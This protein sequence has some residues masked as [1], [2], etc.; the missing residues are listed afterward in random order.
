MKSIS[1]WFFLAL[2]AISCTPEKKEVAY[3]PI[4]YKLY[5]GDNEAGYF[6]SWRSAEGAYQYEMEYND[7]GRGPHLVETIRLNADGYS[8]SIEITGHNYL[9]DTVSERF[10]ISEN[11]ATWE[12]TSENGKAAVAGGGFYVGV[13]SGYGNVE[14]LIRK[15]L[16]LPNKSLEIYPSGRLSI[17]AIEEIKLG[18]TLNLKLIEVV[19]YGFSP[20]YYWFDTSDRFFAA[21]SSWLTAIKQGYESVTDELLAIQLASEKAYYAKTARELTKTPVGKVIISNV[22]LFDSKTGTNLSDRHVVID[23]NTIEVVLPG[24]E[25]LPEAAEVIDGKGKTLM[26]GL[27]DMHTH[28][29]RSDGILNLAGGVTSVRD[30]ANSFDLPDIAN[31]F[32]NNSVIGP[33]ILVMS[34]FID[35]AGPYAGPIGKIISSLDE[36]LEA[37]AFYKERGYHQIKLYSSIDTFHVRWLNVLVPVFKWE[38]KHNNYFFLCYVQ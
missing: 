5:F 3:Q 32:D 12:S 14:L 21:P 9:K 1:L 2:I 8:E 20:N 23:G 26:P 36:G 31:E 38:K 6:K 33:R 7:R 15:M 22:T 34:G 10:V 19:G 11:E 24:G 13:N 27:F 29:S 18:D 4:D 17:S 35:Q 16:S 28:L 37:I 25:A 30:L